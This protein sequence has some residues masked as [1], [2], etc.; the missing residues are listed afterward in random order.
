MWTLGADNLSTQYYSCKFYC[1]IFFFSIETV[2]FL[3]LIE[4]VLWARHFTSFHSWLTC[5]FMLCFTGGGEAGSEEGSSGRGQG[6]SNEGTWTAAERG[7]QH[8]MAQRCSLTFIQPNK[9]DG[10]MS[11]NCFSQNWSPV[12]LTWKLAFFSLFLLFLHVLCLVNYNNWVSFCK[13]HICINR[14][15]CRAAD[16]L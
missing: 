6:Y 7:I 14:Q 12:E 8:K 13:L 4:C 2:P 5:V 11:R 9:R 3:E 15:W 1:A 10:I 16:W